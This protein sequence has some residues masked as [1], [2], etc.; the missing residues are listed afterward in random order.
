MGR[1]GIG[2]IVVV[3]AVVQEVDFAGQP[4]HAPLTGAQPPAAA[5]MGDN[6]VVG[7]Q[8][9][10]AFQVGSGNAE[11]IAGGGTGGG[12]GVHVDEVAVNAVAGDVGQMHTRGILV[13]R[14]AGGAGVVFKDDAV[15]VVDAQDAVV[16]PEDGGVLDPQ[17]GEPVGGRAQDDVPAAAPDGVVDEGDV[18]DLKGKGGIVAGRGGGARSDGGAGSGRG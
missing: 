11:H 2:G 12:A 5:H 14:V 13:V 1:G 3:D 17:A 7:H 18:P 8:D 16:R 9:F 4:D 6:H 15:N 10:T